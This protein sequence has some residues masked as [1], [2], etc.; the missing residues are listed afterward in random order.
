MKKLIRTIKPRK[1]KKKRAYDNTLRSEKSDHAQKEIIQNYVNLLAKS[2]GA[3]ISIDELAL[4]SKVS[5]RTIFRFFE[6]KQA[7]HIATDQYIQQFVIASLQQIKEKDLYAFA[8]DTFLLYEK[9]EN[10]IMAYMFSPF[11]METRLIFRK[12]LN[13]ILIQQILK[14]KK[15]KM[16]RKVE[17]RLALIVTL[18]NAKIWFDIRTDFKH[19]SL[20]IGEAVSW[21]LKIL[22]DSI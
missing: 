22:I 4:A 9:Y 19:T 14:M 6:D 20:E 21:A 16:N 2:R 18:I 5:Q 17:T 3:E 11:G 1:L 10:L 15:I 12:K 13:E 7:L 8:K